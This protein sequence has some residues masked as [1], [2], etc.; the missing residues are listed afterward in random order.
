V[1]QERYHLEAR[2]ET[3]I[4]ATYLHFTSPP[5]IGNTPHLLPTFYYFLASKSIVERK[6]FFVLMK[7]VTPAFYFLSVD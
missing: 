1:Q 3:L 7:M 2:T 6:D 4:N 5:P